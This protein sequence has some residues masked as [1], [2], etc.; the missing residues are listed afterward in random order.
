MLVPIAFPED[1]DL[2]QF[3]SN[4]MMSESIHPFFFVMAKAEPKFSAKR[5]Y[6]FLYACG[7]LHA[8]P[9]V[10]P[11]HGLPETVLQ[12]KSLAPNRVRRIH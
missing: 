2:I 7:L 3:N 10:I 1:R 12:P 8:H 4:S 9:V 6:L 11:H 5:Q